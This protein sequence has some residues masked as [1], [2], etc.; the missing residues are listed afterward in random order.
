MNRFGRKLG[1]G[2]LMTL[3]VLLLL[4]CVIMAAR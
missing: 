2:S 4:A 1:F 3:I